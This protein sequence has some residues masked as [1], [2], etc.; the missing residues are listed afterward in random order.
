MAYRRYY[1]CGTFKNNGSAVY[2][3]NGIKADTIEKAVFDRLRVAVT[4]P[5]VLWNVD[6]NYQWDMN[7]AIRGA[8]TMRVSLGHGITATVYTK[9]ASG[10]QPAQQSVAWREDGWSWGIQ[11]DDGAGDPV[12]QAK[13]E[14]EPLSEL[15][16]PE[17]SGQ[18]VFSFGSDAPSQ[19]E[20]TWMNARYVLYATGLRAPQ[21]AATMLNLS[22]Y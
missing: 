22:S 9:V 3:S 10:T 1:V 15:R 19:L 7:V 20:F 4:N 13:Q 12:A 17:A 11:A 2:R 21:M 14:V 8:K 5:K 18:G 16:L 6:P